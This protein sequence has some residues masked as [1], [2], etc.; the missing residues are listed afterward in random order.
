[1]VLVTIFDKFQNLPKSF[2]VERSKVII[3]GSILNIFYVYVISQHIA[4]NL[5]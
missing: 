3:T 1:M 4:L 2:L 5:H